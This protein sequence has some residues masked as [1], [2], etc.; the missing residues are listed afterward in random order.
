MN[1]M[2][3]SGRG[4]WAFALTVTAF[5]WGLALVPAALLLPA[6]HGS[7]T[8]SN[9][10]VITHPSATLV[11]EN[12]LWVLGVVGLPAALAVIAWFGLHRRCESASRRGSALA[13]TAIA[14]LLL[15][16][17][18]AAASVG[19]FLLPAALLLIAAA[20]LTPAG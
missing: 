1:R 16:S 12:G 8:S 5:S 7:T 18:L 4:R 20:R 9:S 13:W 17:L 2:P 6:Y 11:G 10:G 14:A 19:P 15:L 3:A